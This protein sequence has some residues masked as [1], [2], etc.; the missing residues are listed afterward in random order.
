MVL[1]YVG[2]IPLPEQGKKHKDQKLMKVLA[3]AFELGRRAEKYGLYKREYPKAPLVPT[4]EYMESL[5]DLQIPNYEDHSIKSLLK[6][7]NYVGGIS[8][9]AGG[10][11]ARIVNNSGFSKIIEEIIDEN[12]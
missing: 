5:S 8:G 10:V 2:H 6:E 3:L 9:D 7:I 12:K 1:R 11:L 4:R